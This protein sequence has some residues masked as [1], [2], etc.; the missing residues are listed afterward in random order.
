M[1]AYDILLMVGITLA[2]FLI[3][4]MVN[5]FSRTQK[6][7]NNFRLIAIT[8]VLFVLLLAIVVGATTITDK[9]TNNKVADLESKLA[10]IKKTSTD[11]QQIRMLLNELPSQLNTNRDFDLANRYLAVLEQKLELERM[12]NSN[13]RGEIYDLNNQLGDL[14]DQLNAIG[15]VVGVY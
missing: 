1:G 9:V 4:L 2:L 5:A 15:V 12:H 13:L 8:G 7:T 6:S 11:D 3:V 14:K 10:K